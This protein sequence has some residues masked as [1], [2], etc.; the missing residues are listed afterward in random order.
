M[1]EAGYAIRALVFRVFFCEQKKKEKKKKE[2]K[3][4]LVRLV[5]RF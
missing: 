1:G 2:E 4:E 3:L 5:D